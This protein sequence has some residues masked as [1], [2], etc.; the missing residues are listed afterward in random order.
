VHN[1]PDTSTAQPQPMLRRRDAVA[2][3]VGIVVGAGIYKAPATVADALRD[4]GWIVAAWLAGAAVSFVGALCY[5]ELATAY[6]SAGG[7]YHFLARA[8]GRNASFLYAWA[9]A[10]VIN[11]GSIALLA[12]V[13]GDYLSTIA[14]LPFHSGAVWAALVIVGLTAH[15]VAGLARSVRAQ[16]LLTAIEVAGLLVVVLAGLL[17]AG[18]PPA[19]AAPFAAA[20][21]ASGAGIAMVFV[22]L[23]YGG[24]NEAAYISAELKVRGAIVFALFAS[25]AI[26]AVCYVAANVALLAALGV[27]G[28]A[29]SAAPAV[30][31]M[32]RAF[33]TLGAGALALFVAVATLTSINATMIVG[34]RSNYA[35]GRDWPA[36]RWLGA[37]DG[38]RATPRAGLLFQGAIALA[39]VVLGAF[40]RDGFEAMVN[41]TAPVFWGF[42]LLVGIALFVL[43]R[44][45]PAAPRPF[46]VPGYPATPLVFCAACAFLLHSSIAYAASQ[47]ALHV[48]LLVMAT[49]AGALVATRLFSNPR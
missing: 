10:T 40:Q 19:D 13:F 15:N 29:A 17:V 20:P 22:L 46:R 48:G 41:F 25:A 33:G 36:L 30:D 18:A 37:W 31:V 39:L 8:Y 45:D 44:R 16:N 11:P 3:I 42:L 47:D 32:R 35:L 5:A 24:W 26:V 9:R 23:T 27:S 4:P 49:G 28:L 43:R 7:D 1:A 2:I 14:P 21:S 6:P 38:R 34:A 12:F